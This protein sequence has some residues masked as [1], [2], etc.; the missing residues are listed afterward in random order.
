MRAGRAALCP[1]PAGVGAATFRERCG[2][3]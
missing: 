2:R 3:C 1:F